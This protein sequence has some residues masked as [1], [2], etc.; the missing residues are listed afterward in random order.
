MQRGRLVSRSV[1][2]CLAVGA[3]LVIAGLAVSA[4]QGAP[5]AP[6]PQADTARNFGFPLTFSIE[7]MDKTAD[8]RTDFSRYAAGRWFDAATIPSDGVQI[9]GLTLMT[10]AVEGQLQAILQDAAAGSATAPKRSPLQQVGDFFAS[11]MDE[12]HLAS[13]GVTPLK[14]ELDRLGKIGTP[15]QLAE[16]LAHLQL[17]TFDQVLFG[18]QV[19]TDPRD[20]TRYIVYVGDADLLMAR[21]NYLQPDAQAIRDGYLTF[22]A[23]D[24]VIA[25][26]SRETATAAAARIL[27]IETRIARKKLTGVELADPRKRFV[28]T[29]YADFKRMLSNIDVDAYFRALGLPT[30]GELIV[31]EGEALRER[32]ALVAELSRR[33]TEEYLRWELT[34][35][36]AGY[37]TPAFVG[38]GV[39]FFRVRY[40][41]VD[42]PPRNRIVGG[43]VPTML[44]HPLA[45]L[46]VAKHFSADDRRAVEELVGRVRT[47]FRGRIAK[48]GWLSPETRQH[49]LDKLDK[50]AITVGYP[51]RWIDYSSVEIRRDDYLGNVFRLNEFR[52]RRDLAKFGQK[53]MEDQFA[54]P[55]KTL[56]IDINAGYDSSKNGIEI[57]AAFLQPPFYD[58]KADAA[59]NYCTIG[60]VIGHELTHGFDSQGRQYDGEG[61]FS[62]W[63][64]AE[65]ARRF[66]AETAKLVAQADAFTGLPGLKLNGA[67]EVGENLADVGGISLAYGAL[68]AYL[69]EHPE[70]NRTIDGFS[71]AQR[72][73]L[74]WGQVWADKTTEN[75]LR[76]TLPVD[77]HPPGV[78]RMI[79]APQ[80]ERGFYEAFGIKP[81]DRTWL[82]EKSRVSIW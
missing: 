62:D 27:A 10:K 51:T 64:T 59:V 55:G 78:Y 16:A 46:F 52:A 32:N 53:V 43:Q 4:Q 38:P 60:A 65:D 39:A 11:G 56:P 1:R 33:D 3:A 17:I 71:P 26:T 44:G 72:C 82:D 81:G 12:Q 61:R 13:L 25:G 14:P 34:R 70:A 20:R 30:S 6:Q 28:L 54:S 47:E 66:Q 49:A 76:Q 68:G 37:L 8:P 2:S 73:F 80:H 31:V 5:A 42:T 36:T 75:A 21:D 40:G 7:K 35:R 45:Q 77:G 58:R 24:L 48:N 29:P 50:V 19:G 67:L 69:R 74:A 23:D 15:T 9:A 57:P 79:A 63:W 22:V 41:N 18:S